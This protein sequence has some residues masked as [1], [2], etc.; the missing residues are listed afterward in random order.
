M[1]ESILQHF[2][3]ATIASGYARIRCPYH[4]GGREKRPSMGILLEDKGT[5][6]AGTCHCF[7]CGKV[8]SFSDMVKELGFTV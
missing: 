3:N 5:M 8:I 6:E 1:V 4:K 2:P 7:T